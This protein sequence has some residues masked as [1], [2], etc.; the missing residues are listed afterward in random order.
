MRN[1]EARGVEP[2]HLARQQAE[3]G[4]AAELGGRVEE[5]LQP[6]ADPEDRDAGLAAL[7]DELVDPELADPLHRARKGADARK[8]QAVGAA[9][10][11]G[12]AGDRDLATPTCSSA[13]STERRFPIP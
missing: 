9:H 3:A 1:L 13:F 2:G 6:E 8:Y 10:R 5:Q 12:V 7:G 11:G 4:G